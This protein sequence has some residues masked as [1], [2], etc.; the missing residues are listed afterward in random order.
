MSFATEIPR[1]PDTVVDAATLQQIYGL[2]IQI[3]TINDGFGKA[4][5]FAEEIA[6]L[7]SKIGRT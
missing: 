1:Q 7:I 4:R 3:L 2:T 6:G 5:L